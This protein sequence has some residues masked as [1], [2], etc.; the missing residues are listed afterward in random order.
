MGAGRGQLLVAYPRILRVVPGSIAADIGIKPGFSLVA[1]NGQTIVDILDYRWALASERLSLT[2]LDD[3]KASWEVDIDK[4]YGEDIGLVFEH[5]TIAPLHNCK[6]NC[7]FCFVAQLP[8]GV[9][10]TLCVK[11]DDYRLSSLH[12][13]FVTLTNLSE[14]DWQRLLT[15]RPSPLY[16]SV[17]TTSGS[18]RAQMM[19]NPKAGQI[20]EQLRLLA[21]HHIEIHCQIVLVPG[22]NDGAELERTIRD[23]RSLWPAVQSVAVVPVGLTAHRDQLPL[24]RKTTQSEAR[25]VVNELL[26]LA[27][28]AQRELGVSFVYLADEFFLLAG[29]RVP[30]RR[31]YDDFPQIENG[32]GLT[33]HL[34]DELKPGLRRLPKRLSSP[35]RVI[36]V[37]GS[38]A[39]PMLQMVAWQLNSIEGLWVDVCAVPN[40]FFGESVTVTGLLTGQDILTALQTIDAHGAQILI[41]EVT[42]RAAERDFLDG[43]T[44]TDL[45][46]ALPQ[47]T[48]I[49]TPVE[50]QA[51][52]TYTLGGEA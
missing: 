36:W 17:H 32:I 25:A 7:L 13:S 47:A 26:P 3:T 9:R 30:A 11:D 34:L 33:R 41:P 23:L 16:V 46:Q 48:M 6:N 1:V 4:E 19:R 15:M 50:G 51:L 21:E 35:R 18:L 14:N 37:T 38:L 43:M 10:N 52:I 39:A 29:S 12:G 31:Y 22:V 24:L 28:Q 49:A 40:R 5:P 8:P 20:M 44:F 2:L 42:L 45:Q 27:R